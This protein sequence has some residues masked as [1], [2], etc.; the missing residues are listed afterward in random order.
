MFLGSNR[1][2]GPHRGGRPRSP[3][4]RRRRCRRASVTRRQYTDT[5]EN[6]ASPF[7]APLRPLVSWKAAA[8][9]ECGRRL[10]DQRQHRHPAGQRLPQPG[11]GVQRAATRGGRDD[12]ESGAAAAV[13]VGHGGGGEL[14]LGQH[15]GD[16]VDG[17]ARRRRDLR[18][19]RRPRRRC[20][21][22][23]MAARCSTMWS[24]T[25]YCLCHGFTCLTSPPASTRPASNFG[26]PRSGLKVLFA[27][28]VAAHV[29]VGGTTSRTRSGR[30][31][32]KCCRRL[33]RWHRSARPMS[34]VGS[35]YRRGRRPP[36]P[37]SACFV[38]DAARILAVGA[39]HVDLRAPPR[40]S[41]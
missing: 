41:G 32:S 1:T 35:G 39:D 7:S 10:A 37:G 4:Q 30:S 26:S 38:L 17:S 2:A 14:V 24:T 19:W 21:S 6:S 18:C 3:R 27:A 28:N 33:T 34:R 31:A 23:P 16:V 22:T 8:A 36:S 20:G 15:R 9:V 40:P 25:R 12:A 29:V 11:N 5:A 13:S